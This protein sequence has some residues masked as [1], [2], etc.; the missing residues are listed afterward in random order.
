MAEL[1]RIHHDWNEV[2]R[3]ATEDNLLRQRTTASRVRLL[4][5]IRYRLQQLTPRELDFFCDA[6]S[7]EQRQILLIAICQRFRF[8]REF[9]EEVLF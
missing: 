6:D 1:L 3:R 5:E 2:A 9:V 4:R 8:I 7:R